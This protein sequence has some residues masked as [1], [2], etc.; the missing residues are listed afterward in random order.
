MS[1]ARA[2][3]LVVGREVVDRELGAHGEASDV[4]EAHGHNGDEESRRVRDGTSETSGGLKS[5]RQQKRESCGG[6]V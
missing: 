1:D 5:P 4:V 3:E 6:A 2:R